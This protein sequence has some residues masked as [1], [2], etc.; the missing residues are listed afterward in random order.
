[1]EGV[2]SAV[3]PQFINGTACSLRG[4]T[5]RP[6]TPPVRTVFGIAAT[7]GICLTECAERDRVPI[8]TSPSQ[9]QW[10]THLD[11]SGRTTA[12]EF[13]EKPLRLLLSRFLSGLGGNVATS[14]YHSKVLASQSTPPM[15]SERT[16]PRRRALAIAA[17]HSVGNPWGCGRGRRGN[18]RTCMENWQ[19]N[20]IQTL[21]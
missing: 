14:S 13:H 2:K 21:H 18:A 3:H 1:M 10:H 7:R 9:Y 19:P 20:E 17:A 5:A 6:H 11:R 4:C 16:G 15:V 8:G 12:E